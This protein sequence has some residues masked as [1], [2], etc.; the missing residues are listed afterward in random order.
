MFAA[1]RMADVVGGTA[2]SFCGTFMT[3]KFSITSNWFLRFFKFNTLSSIVPSTHA[4]ISLHR[5]IP[6][7]DSANR[8]S[9]SM[10]RGIIPAR[11][12][13][14]SRSIFKWAA[15]GSH[16]GSFTPLCLLFCE[17]RS[18]KIKNASQRTARNQNEM[19]LNF[20]GL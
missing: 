4:L 12:L 2:D 16:C 20:G 17:P 18:L 15:R 14:F 6:S 10:S 11:S 7:I 9:P 5:R 3:F 1:F 13:S 8:S 19:K